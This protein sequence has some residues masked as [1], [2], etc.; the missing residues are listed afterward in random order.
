MPTFAYVARDSA[1]QTRR[2]TR[3]GPTEAAVVE[4]LRAGGLLTLEVRRSASGGDGMEDVPG[5]RWLGFW[6]LF[7]PRSVD[8]EVG[9][10]QI[11]FM[12]RSGVPLLSAL[13]TC[14]QQSV[15][16]SMARVWAKVANRVQSGAGFSEAL[17]DHR[18]FPDIVVAMVSIGEQTGVLEDVLLR[19][20]QTLER[21]R[22]LKTAVVTAMMYPAIVVVMAIGLVAYM[23]V[24]LIP[25]LAKML[26]SFGRRMPPLTKLL[27]DISTFVHAHFIEGLVI[28]VSSAIMFAI[29]YAWPP[30]RERIDRALLSFP[31]VG[32]VLRLSATASF[33]RNLGVLV[34]SGVRVTEGLRVVE[35]LLANRYVA[36][37]IASAREQVLQGSNL[38]EPLARSAA[39]YP[40][41]SNMVAVG[42][43]SGTLDE[44]LGHVATFHEMRLEAV[45]RRLSSLIE[46][47]IVVVVGG[48]VG[49]IYMA[50]FMAL[51]GFAGGR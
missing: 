14:S 22:Q 9:L 12:L 2:G 41:L 44:A 40:M 49:F 4:S 47:V 21:R 30:A 38:A 27:I 36:L 46:P 43:A 13:R 35:P 32:S 8:V 20:A 31:I 28:A 24:G 37:R 51:Y 18:C 6:R 34:S 48:I 5:A 25:K 10:Q 50:F 29:V 11:A 7:R 16:Y 17:R 42:E 26:A 3:E 33:S 39:F 45:I 19:V 23:M 1:G 15:R